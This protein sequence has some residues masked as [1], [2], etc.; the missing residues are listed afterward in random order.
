MTMPTF[1]D[2]SI[3]TAANLNAIATGISNLGTLLT[4]IAATR[5]YIPTVA[6]TI[7]AP[8]AMPTALDTLVDLTNATINNDY[9]YV[10]SRSE[11][12]IQTAGIYVAYAQVNWDGNTAGVRAAHILLNGT[13]IS[14]SVAASTTN[15]VTTAGVGTCTVL[16]TPPMS[17]AAG[18]ILY[19]SVF[20]NSGGNLNLIL[21]ESG[22][23]L[24]VIRLGA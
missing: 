4:G 6:A 10:T 18:A 2:G 14:N 17:L 8:Q 11:P 15:P 24:T 3:T 7:N 21:N 16:M 9:D 19:L 20:Q 12:T 22:T 5:L 1:T 23:Y 13:A